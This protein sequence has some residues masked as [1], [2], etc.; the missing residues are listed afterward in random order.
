MKNSPEH[1]AP[2]PNQLER[3]IGDLESATSVIEHLED[4][5]YELFRSTLHAID[6]LRTAAQAAR[7]M[8]KTDFDAVADEIVRIHD[9]RMKLMKQ[10]EQV[11][12]QIEGL[13]SDF[14]HQ[15]PKNP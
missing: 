6:E 14:I 7:A 8:E 12:N 15:K 4:P 3:A 13:Q 11:G 10:L 2:E 1:I 5:R 9:L